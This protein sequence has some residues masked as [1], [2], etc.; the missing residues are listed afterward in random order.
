MLTK[1]NEELKESLINNK[2]WQNKNTSQTTIKEKCNL[3][4]DYNHIQKLKEYEIF[5]NNNS[6][7]LLEEQKY[8][9]NKFIT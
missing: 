5:Y 4:L 3:I 7:Y 2:S 8:K 1:E 9:C 6:S